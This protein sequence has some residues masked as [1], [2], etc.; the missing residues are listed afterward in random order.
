MLEE[1]LAGA[2][3]QDAP[4]VPYEVIV[5]DNHSTDAT[6][7]AVERHINDGHDNLRYVFEPRQGVSFARN[8]GLAE[9]RADIVAFSDDDVRVGRNWV[10]TIKR[11]FDE[12]PG[13]DCIGGKVLPIW[14]ARAPAWLTR[15][16]WTPLA[17]QDYGDRQVL[18]DL[19]N[20]LCLISA[21]LAFRRDVLEHIGAFAPELQRVKNNIGSM[22]DAEL[23]ERYFRAGRRCLYVPEMRVETEITPERLTRSYHRRWHTGH[24]HFYAIMRAS[25]MERSSSRL[26]DVPSHLYKQAALD[27]AGWLWFTPGNRSRAFVHETRLRFFWGFFRKRREDYLAAAHPS[28]LPEVIAFVRSLASRKACGESQKG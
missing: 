22:E 15:E 24:G 18:I 16:H 12:R 19:E 27:A 3:S 6:R 25:E 4:G 1:C 11:V 9:A 17:L 26:F 21:N 14:S 7:E 5:V 8:T 13:I 20:P 28:F 2:L 23:L 10:A